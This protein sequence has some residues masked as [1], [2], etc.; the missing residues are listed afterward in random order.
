MLEIVIEEVIGWDLKK[1]EARPEGGLFGIPLAFTA[2]TEEQGRKTLHTHFLIWLKNF[3]ERR[4]KLYSE[5]IREQ[6]AACK[7]SLCFSGYNCKLL[8]F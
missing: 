2:S 4:A 5:N 3:Q 6:K 8:S 1:N 7:R